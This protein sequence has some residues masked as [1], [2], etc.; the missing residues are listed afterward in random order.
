M[1]AKFKTRIEFWA[2]IQDKKGTASDFIVAIQTVDFNL[3]TLEDLGELEVTYLTR[4]INTRFETDPLWWKALVIYNE[5][6]KQYDRRSYHEVLKDER[7]SSSCLI[8]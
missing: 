3:L 5:R 6:L 7:F 8:L 4:S 1:T 2:S